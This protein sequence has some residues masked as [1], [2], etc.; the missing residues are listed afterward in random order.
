MGFIP[1]FL[2]GG[3]F[4]RSEMNKKLDEISDAL[5]PSWKFIDKIDNTKG[6]SGEWTAPD[7]FGDGSAYD[8][9]VYMIGGG[10]SGGVAASSSGNEN[11]VPVATGGASGY[12][13]NVIIKNVSPGA[14]Y[15]WV[16]G[17]GGAKVSAAYNNQYNQG[18]AGGTTSF[19]NVTTSGGGG[20]FAYYNDS[21]TSGR[22]ANGGQGSDSRYTLLSPRDLF[23][24]TPTIQ[25]T[26][27]GSTLA[28]GLS[29]SSRLGQNWFDPEMVSLC[30]GG[31]AYA[32]NTSGQVI[33]AMPDGTRG[34]S[35]GVGWVNGEAATGY[36]NGGGGAIRVGVSSGTGYSGAGSDGVIFL[37]ARKA[38]TE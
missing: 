22:G 34:G 2:A 21:G 32:R 9:G 19:N 29:Q 4:N 31:F 6:Y 24:C 25:G 35:G 26:S 7:V 15:S 11:F 14:T 20:G 17:K 37:Y 5:A 36:G 28:G 33:N 8:L 12:G 13:K 1:H 30:A 18:N 3:L 38:V 16:V 10:G 23:G 27:G